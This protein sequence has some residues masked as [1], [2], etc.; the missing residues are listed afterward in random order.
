[1][2]TSTPPTSAPHP[3]RRSLTAR[4]TACTQ[5][6]AHRS[7]QSCAYQTAKH[8]RSNRPMGRPPVC[9]FSPRGPS[10][11]HLV[12]RLPDD[13][14]RDRKPPLRQPRNRHERH[15]CSP[16]RKPRH[17]HF[18]LAPGT[19]DRQRI[20]TRRVSRHLQLVLRRRL[21]HGRQ[22]PAAVFATP[23]LIDHVVDN[24]GGHRPVTKERTTPTG[25]LVR[26]SAIH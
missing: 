26:L 4:V 6:V 19:T 9:E 23:V 1:M 14:R 7:D 25:V 10:A 13:H 2:S 5:R 21:H 24:G 20:A 8:H 22:D 17:H 11:A 3:D 12:V 18:H 16:Q 15:T